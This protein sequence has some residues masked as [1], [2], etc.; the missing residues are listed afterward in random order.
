[1]RL[2][3]RRMRDGARLPSRSY[4]GDAGLD[5]Y[6]LE[7]MRL[8]PFERCVAPTGIAIEL[9]AG[10]VGLLVPRSG[11]AARGLS[12]ADAPA[13]IDAGYRGELRVQLQ[14]IDAREHVDVQP[15]DRI[16]QLLVF[17]FT[18]LEPVEVDVLE[19]SSRGESGLGSTGR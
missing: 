4:A 13:V 14:N 1:M 16:A 8:A 11:H 5:L 19:S 2:K 18:A 17:A 10:H 7:A 12:L 9:P 6:A 15:G 3:V